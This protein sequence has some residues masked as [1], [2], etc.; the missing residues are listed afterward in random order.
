MVAGIVGMKM[1]RYCLFGETASIASLM[2][3]T[4]QPMKIHITE[5]VQKLLPHD[6]VTSD[7]F[8]VDVT[9]QTDLK[10]CKGIFYLLWDFFFLSICLRLGFM[11]TR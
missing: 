7:N 11:S 6:F 4:S 5:A 9:R 10:N 2:E 1:P 8:K 3:S